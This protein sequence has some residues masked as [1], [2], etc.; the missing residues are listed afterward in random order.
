MLHLV[1]DQLVV[2]QLLMEQL[3]VVTYQANHWRFDCNNSYTTVVFVIDDDDI[4]ANLQTDQADAA[5]AADAVD[6]IL[7]DGQLLGGFVAGVGSHLV[8]GLVATAGVAGQL[9]GQIVN[10]L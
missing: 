2:H 5:D 8:G 9:V 3:F 10:I 1:T 7:V 4:V 6:G